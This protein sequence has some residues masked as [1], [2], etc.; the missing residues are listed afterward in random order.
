[1]RASGQCG[2]A[3]NN[4]PAT[5]FYGGGGGANALSFS[6]GQGVAIGKGAQVDTASLSNAQAGNTGRR[7][8]LA[9]K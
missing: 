2:F 7:M 8:L 3:A 1:M 4:A 5:W 9:A 6:N